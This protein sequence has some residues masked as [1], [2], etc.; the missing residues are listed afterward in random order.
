MAARRAITCM[1]VTEMSAPVGCG[2]YRQPPS[3]F[4]LRTIRSTAFLS[5]RLDLLVAGH[6]PQLGEG[7]RGHAV[8]V[9]VAAARAD[10]VAVVGAGGGDQ[11]AGALGDLGAVLPLV[12]QVALRHERQQGEG[13]DGGV[14]RVAPSLQEPSAFCLPASHSRRLGGRL[15]GGSSI[16]TSAARGAAGEDGEDRRGTTAASSD[17]ASADAGVRKGT[18]DDRGK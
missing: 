5:D 14:V 17:G 9:H 11:E 7:E 3:R 13:G 2:S 16:F 18:S 10:E 1:I 12:G 6:A 4:W 8:A 15:L